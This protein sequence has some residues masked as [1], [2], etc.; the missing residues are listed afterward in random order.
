MPTEAAIKS[1]QWGEKIPLTLEINNEH[2]LDIIDTKCRMKLKGKA[3]SSI[4]KH[5][6]VKHFALIGCKVKCR[7]CRCESFTCQSL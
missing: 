6:L 1:I 2:K 5:Q 7:Q 3:R 4:D